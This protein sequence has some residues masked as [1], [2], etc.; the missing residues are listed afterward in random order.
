MATYLYCV[1]APPK[2]DAFPSGLRGIAGAPVRPVVAPAR[3][4]IEAWVATI[5]DSV[6]RSTGRM[7]AE[8]ALLH[9]EVVDAALATGRTPLPARFGSRFRDDA[10]CSSHL[11]ERHAEL[12]AALTRVAGAVEM[13]L[14][15]VPNAERVETAADRP[16]RDEPAAGRRY[17]EAIRERTQSAERRRATADRLAARIGSA[18]AP[19]V[20]GEA[21]RSDSLGV[22]SVAHLVDYADLER[23][24]RAVALLSTDNDFRIVV[25]G[26]RAP[27]SFAQESATV[28]GHDSSSPNHDE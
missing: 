2:T 3:S 20:R 1:L 23:Y 11:E 10:A 6:L 12:Q 16:R 26:P 4:G 25:A 19:M 27:Y 8:Q 14:L 21:R 24:R 22:V 17:L 15:L 28:V 13:A 18:V 7:L 5:E 9:N